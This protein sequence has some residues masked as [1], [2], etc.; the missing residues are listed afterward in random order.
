LWPVFAVLALVVIVAAVVRPGIY[1]TVG[2]VALA[3]AAIVAYLRGR[4]E[5]QTGQA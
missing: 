4:R 5:R 3:G 1:Q 2:A